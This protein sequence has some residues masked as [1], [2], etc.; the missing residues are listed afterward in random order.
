MKLLDR[1]L[2]AQV[3][4]MICRPLVFIWSV[5]QIA[6]FAWARWYLVTLGLM[7]LFAVVDVFFQFVARHAFITGASPQRLYSSHYF[8]GGCVL[9]VI[10][11]GIFQLAFFLDISVAVIMLVSVNFYSAFLNK[12]EASIASSDAIFF[13]AIGEVFGYILCAL[14][15]LGGAVLIAAILATIAF[16]LAR[17]IAVLSDKWSD[18]GSMKAPA[19]TCSRGAFVGSAVSA[20]VLASLAAGAPSI[21]SFIIPGSLNRIGAALI[22]FKILFAASALLSTAVNLLSVRVF[23]RVVIFDLGS[24]IIFAR[25]AEKTLLIGLPVIFLA[26]FTTLDQEGALVIAFSIGLGLAFSY[27][28]LLSSLAAMRGKPSVSAVAQA[29]VFGGAYSLAFLINE[30]IAFAGLSFLLLICCF[31]AL[32][33]HVRVSDLLN[34][35]ISLYA[36]S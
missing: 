13:M 14:I 35:N 25:V 20:Q 16:P 31:Y 29:G 12:F 1:T 26:T 24:K 17:I 21:A 28:N 8:G 22:T 30:M 10:I 36:R 19:S 9:V 5:S 4:L 15:A 2:F 7:P 34:E 3:V 23:Y 32:A 27:L 6:D 33:Y 18:L 11:A